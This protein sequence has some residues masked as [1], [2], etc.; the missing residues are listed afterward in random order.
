MLADVTPEE[1]QRGSMVAVTVFVYLP[2][3][4]VPGVGRTR[5]FMVQRFRWR[6]WWI[7]DLDWN[8]VITVEGNGSRVMRKGGQKYVRQDNDRNAGART[9]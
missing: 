5:S 2:A 4:M 9:S 8:A 1:G 3:A 7:L 6:L